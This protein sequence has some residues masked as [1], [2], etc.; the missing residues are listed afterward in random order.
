MNVERHYNIIAYSFQTNLQ[1][2]INKNY[3][4]FYINIMYINLFW[5]QIR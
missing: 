5:S 4:R 1:F 3:H 2:K